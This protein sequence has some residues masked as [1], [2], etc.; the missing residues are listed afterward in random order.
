MQRVVTKQYVGSV[1][2]TRGEATCRV[3]QVLHSKKGVLQSVIFN[4]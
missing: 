2:W 4:Y 3:N 1:K